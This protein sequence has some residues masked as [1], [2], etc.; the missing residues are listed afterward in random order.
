[1]GE[2]ATGLHTCTCSVRICSAGEADLSLWKESPPELPSPPS[3]HPP[4]QVLWRPGRPV[5]P[6]HPRGIHRAWS[7][8]TDV[9]R[10]G[11]EFRAGDASV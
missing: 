5:D 11:D 6:V 3:R 8:L 7:G 1:M 2:V 10:A 9:E 4:A